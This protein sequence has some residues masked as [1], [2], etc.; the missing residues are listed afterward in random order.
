M[1]HI[2]LQ[3]LTF[4]CLEKSPNSDFCGR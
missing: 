4:I 2:L 1:N 3:I